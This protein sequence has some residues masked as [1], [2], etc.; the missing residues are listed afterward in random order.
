[1]LVLQ[2][3]AHIPRLTNFSLVRGYKRVEGTILIRIKRSNRYF[4]CP[5]ANASSF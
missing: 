5:V 2:T 1:M 4:F 3:Y